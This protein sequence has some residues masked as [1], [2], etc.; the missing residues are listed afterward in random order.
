MEAGRNK[1]IEKGWKQGLKIKKRKDEVLKEGKVGNLIDGSGK[2]FYLFVCSLL[3]YYP[4][5]T[6]IYILVTYSLHEVIS[7]DNIDRYRN[8]KNGKRNS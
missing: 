8:Y 7:V 6:S 2:Y 1:I 3:L 4:V 5:G